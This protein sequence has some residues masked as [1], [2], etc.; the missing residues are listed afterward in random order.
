MRC[1]RTLW[2]ESSTE[3]V[4]M[5]ATRPRQYEPEQGWNNHLFYRGVRAGGYSMAGAP[6]FDL[7]YVMTRAR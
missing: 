1:G 2:P 7:P 3:P 5:E 4:F 6:V